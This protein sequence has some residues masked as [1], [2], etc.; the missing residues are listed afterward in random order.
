MLLLSRF[1]F[2]A[3]TYS[4]IRVRVQEGNALYFHFQQNNRRAW[5]PLIIKMFGTRHPWCSLSSADAPCKP[6]A[7]VAWLS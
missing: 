3:F 4:L 2:F 5:R 6:A 7:R 1:C